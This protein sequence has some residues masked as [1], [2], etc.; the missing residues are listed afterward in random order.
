MNILKDT[1]DG[2][3]WQP[4]HFLGEPKIKTLIVKYHNTIK[5][6]E[7]E[8]T[9]DLNLFDYDI[10]LSPTAVIGHC[11]IIENRTEI[12]DYAVLFPCSYVKSGM[13]IP[14]Y[15]AIHPQTVMSENY[16][17]SYEGH[18]RA[19]NNFKNL[20]KLDLIAIDYTK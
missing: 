16:A 15:A 7:F 5:V 9:S 10:K 13:K 11:C 18:G 19:G 14:A 8:K 3:Q 6:F 1:F 2:A 20:I 12:G 4:S 17:D